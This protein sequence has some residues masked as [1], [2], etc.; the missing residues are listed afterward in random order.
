MA[1][2][3]KMSKAQNRR[4]MIMFPLFA[5]IYSI[6]LADTALTAVN[7]HLLLRFFRRFAGAA[8]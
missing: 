6:G 2:T 7:T 3:T 8:K 1:N 5:S 4:N